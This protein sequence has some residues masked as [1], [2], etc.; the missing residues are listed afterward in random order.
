M[1]VILLQKV[2]NRGDLG[3]VVSVKN[4]YARNYLIPQGIA[5]R[6]TK[7][8]IA[9]FES[10]KAELKQKAVEAMSA[11]EQK[12]AELS[13]VEISISR[14]A[15]DEGKLFGSVGTTDIAEAIVAAGVEITKKDVRLP[16][17]AFREVGEFDVTIHLMTGVDAEVK[18]TVVAE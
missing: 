4:G 2:Q 15:G 6:A 18:I 17:G 16:D 14:K 8:N 12:K 3:D 13:K 1:E 10:R 11:A 5:T 7:A 9:G